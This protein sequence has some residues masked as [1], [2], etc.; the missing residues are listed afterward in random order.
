MEPGEFFAAVEGYVEEREETMQADWE[1]GRMVAYYSVAGHLKKSQNAGPQGLFKFPWE[2][3]DKP[4]ELTPDE[5]QNHLER[6]E[7][8]KFR[9]PT[10]QEI[11]K[12]IN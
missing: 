9:P 1:I 10:A 2:I 4:R 5:I 12:L 6:M 3:K 7:R 8:V 11:K